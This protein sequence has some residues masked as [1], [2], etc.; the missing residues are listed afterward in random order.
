MCL[1]N[2]FKGYSDISRQEKDVCMQ[3]L[4][5]GETFSFL[6]LSLKQGDI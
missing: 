5:K 3:C 4:R 6:E 1:D 2:K